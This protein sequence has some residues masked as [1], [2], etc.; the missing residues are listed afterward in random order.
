MKT[1]LWIGA[2]VLAILAQS[3]LVTGTDLILW[4]TIDHGQTPIRALVLGDQ[5]YYLLRVH[6]ALTAGSPIE[7]PYFAEHATGT[8]RF[9]IFETFV[10][11]I[12]GTLF[13]PLVGTNA[14]FW[15]DLLRA[16]AISGLFLGLY[17]V[18]RKWAGIPP[19]PAMAFALA[20]NF[21]Q[22]PFAQNSQYALGSW[23][24][25]IILFGVIL[26]VHGLSSKN[27]LKK[28]ALLFA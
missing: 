23:F 16:L 25:P 2:L 26:A 22:E 1:K 24:V 6:A 18:F 14:V 20:I 19:Y 11:H 15:A 3:A 4:K 10:V 12:L 28:I 5:D 8:A 17:Y 13:V 7:S 27:W 21:W 9:F